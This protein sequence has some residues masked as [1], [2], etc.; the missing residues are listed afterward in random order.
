VLIKSELHKST[1]PIAQTWCSNEELNFDHA[2]ISR[3][4]C[5]VELFEH[6]LYGPTFVTDTG[7]APTSE[8][9]GLPYFGPT[10][11]RM[12]ESNTRS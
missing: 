11:C 6:K 8:I 5:A 3:G 4:L 9:I 1:L 2:I 10:W 7:T 12:S